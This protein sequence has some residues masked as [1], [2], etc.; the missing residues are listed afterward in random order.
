MACPWATDRWGLTV[1]LSSA[2]SQCPNHLARTWVTAC[3]S[4]LC[5]TACL[6]SAI[7][8]GSTPSNRRV[9]TAFA[10][11]PTM[12][13]IIAAITT[14][15]SAAA[16]WNPRPTARQVFHPTEAVGEPGT[17]STPGEQKGHPQGH[18]RR[19]IADVVDG[20]GEQRD[21]ARQ[22]DDDQLQ[23][24][25]HTKDHERPLDGPDAARRRGDD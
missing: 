11:C 18:R 20:I 13:K 19:R 9:K 14:P 17:A 22:Q 3:T 15:I 16:P 7:T 24:S 23:S 21:A 6:I 1:I 25:R 4:G 8:A 12:P 10:D 2:C 5:C